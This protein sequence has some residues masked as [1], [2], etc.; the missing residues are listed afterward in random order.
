MWTELEARLASMATQNVVVHQ[1]AAPVKAVQRKVVVQQKV[2]QKVQ[3]APATQIF[4]GWSEA[5]TTKV[6]LS[7]SLAVCGV[8][9]LSLAPLPTSLS[10]SLAPSSRSLL[11]LSI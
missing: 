6:S 7:L 9:A 3:Q 4:G 11:S 2:Q 5:K 8:R 1:A 10:L